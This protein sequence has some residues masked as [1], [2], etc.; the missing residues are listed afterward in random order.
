MLFPGNWVNSSADLKWKAMNHRERCEAWLRRE[1]L[2]RLPVVEWAPW[3]DLTLQRWRREGL[4]ADLKGIQINRLLG[5]DP[6]QR[7]WLRSLSA[8][9]P[10][11]PAVHG[12]PR[13]TCMD[14]YVTW[15]RNGWLYPPLADGIDPAWLAQQAREQ[16]VGKVVTWLTFD[17]FFWF[18]RML[19]GIELHLYAF[20][21]QPELMHAINQDLAQYHLRLLEELRGTLRPCFMC[22]AEDMSYNHGPMLSKEQFDAFLLPYY[23]QVIP[24]LEDLGI[25]PMIDSDGDVTSMIPWLEQAGLRGLLPW[26]RQAGVDLQHIRQVHPDFLILGGYDKRVMHQGEAAIRAEFERLT[27][28]MR[29]GGYLP[30][31][32][33]Q[34]P[35]EVA[36]A[37]YRTYVRVLHEYASAACPR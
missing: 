13:L 6:Y 21:D 31:C 25:T 28:V 9:A 20:Y 36:L 19:L 14:D 18:P 26:E 11:A 1:P 16:A 8:S 33:H 24:A 17:G 10:P 15:K 32:D 27:P 3:W 29:R 4:P 22:F 2:D 23:Q 34:T 7:I 12:A 35:P 37:D 5:L 30:S